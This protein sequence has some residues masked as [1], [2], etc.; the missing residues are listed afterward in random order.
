MSFCRYEYGLSV[1]CSQPVYYHLF[2]VLIV[3]S[4][5]G[6]ARLSRLGRWIHTKYLPISVLTKSNL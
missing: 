2:L 3:S 1:S 4:H 5:R 6:M